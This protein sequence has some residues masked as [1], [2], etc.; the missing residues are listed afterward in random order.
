MSRLRT[1]EKAKQDVERKPSTV[2]AQTAAVEPDSPADDVAAETQPLQTDAPGLID[3]ARLDQAL[4]TALLTADRPMPPGKLAQAL[5]EAGVPAQSATA[6][7]VKSAVERLNESYSGSGRAFR[8]ENVAG[9]FRLMTLPEFVNVVVAVRGL[10]ESQRLS[11]AGVETLAIVAYRQ[12]ITRSE[13]ES[14][15]GSASGEVLRTLLEKR[16]V[17]IVGRA[18]E[19]GRPMLYG[20]SRRFL[21]VFGLSSLR[22]L[23]PISEAF[24]GVDLQKLERVTRA[25]AEPSPQ[26]SVEPQPAQ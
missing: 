23:P 19:L 6:A 26:P 14:I 12:P 3:P 9:G 2:A 20:T 8:I 7:A 1:S 5:D 25:A 22:D 21:E 4:E 24:P 16:L 18:E 13:I 17:A 10:R 11:R 15:R